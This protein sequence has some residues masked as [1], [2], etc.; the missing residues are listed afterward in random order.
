MEVRGQVRVPKRE[1]TVI[2]PKEYTFRGG[3]N[4][5]NDAHLH[6]RTAVFGDNNMQTIAT[7]LAQAQQ[8]AQL[9]AKYNTVTLK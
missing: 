2:S 3:S 8:G 9:F 6:L 1:Y 4:L 5:L 7:P